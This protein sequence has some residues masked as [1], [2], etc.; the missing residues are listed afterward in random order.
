M[1]NLIFIPLLLSLL[2]S[3]STFSQ[4]VE[5]IPT[6]VTSA[7]EEQLKRKRVRISNLYKFYLLIKSYFEVKVLRTTWISTASTLSCIYF[8]NWIWDIVWVT[9]IMSQCASK[10]ALVFVNILNYVGCESANIYKQ[11]FIL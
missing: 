9:L 5:T 7:E 6:C 3:L 2:F 1:K 4:T 11:P 10:S 8:L